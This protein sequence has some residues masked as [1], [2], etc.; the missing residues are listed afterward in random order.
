MK[1]ALIIGA[2]GFVGGYLIEHLQSTNNYEIVATKL[3]NETINYK[4]ITVY[5]LNILNKDDILSILEKEKPNY[6]FHLAA[7]SSVALSWKNPSLTVDINIKGSL[8]LLE[9]LREINYSPLP[10]VLMIGSGE[11]YGYVTADEIPI[12][13]SNN[14][15]PGNIYAVTKVCQNMLSTVYAKAYNLDV[16]NVRAFNHIGPRQSELFVISDFC[17][18]VAEIE[19]YNKEPIIYVGNLNVK[20]D[21]TDVRD[22]VNAYE[23]LILKGESGKT[24]NVGSGK[25]IL[26]KDIL[27]LILSKAR[28]N[29]TVEIDHKKFRP[30]DIP[31]IEADVKE[32][33]QITGWEIKNN[34]EDTINDILEYWRNVV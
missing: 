32:L 16:M 34:I 17:K 20:R 15:R 28:Q 27:S 5:D 26:I 10:R 23:L 33:K 24:Y 1:K 22:I 25:S 9:S 31:N 29:I 2:C 12:S 13:E 18:Q 8:N 7:Q 4:N 3:P 14:V 30:S 6:I 19:K 21:F 11:E